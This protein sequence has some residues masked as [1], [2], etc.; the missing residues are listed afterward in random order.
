MG[1]SWGFFI[2]FFVTFNIISA[3]KIWSQSDHW[4]GRYGQFHIGY[5]QVTTQ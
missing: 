1:L 2:P 5:P 3:P 4:F